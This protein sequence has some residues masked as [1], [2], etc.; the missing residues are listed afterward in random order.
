MSPKKNKKSAPG[1][2]KPIE[3]LLD[4]SLAL[5]RLRSEAQPWPFL[6]DAVAGVLGAQRVLLV[7]QQGDEIARTSVE[8][9]G[10]DADFAPDMFT[11]VPPPDTRIMRVVKWPEQEAAW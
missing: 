9:L 7:L 4:I 1:A 6:A 8:I 2:D 11:I 3:R 5:N 10:V